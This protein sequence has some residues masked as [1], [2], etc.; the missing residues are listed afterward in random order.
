MHYSPCAP[1]LPALRVTHR[2]A[3]PTLVCSSI[4]IYHRSSVELFAEAAQAR[5]AY[6]TFDIHVP[7]DETIDYR[8]KKA[9]VSGYL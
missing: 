8:A 9:I 5:N 7:V 3:I 1:L 6:E 2:D 4:G